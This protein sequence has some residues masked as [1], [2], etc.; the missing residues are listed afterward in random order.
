MGM[1]VYGK[2][3]KTQKGEYFRNNVWYWHPLWDYCQYVSPEIAT[4]VNY[5]HSNDG[6]GLDNVNARKLGFALSASIEDGTAEEYIENYYDM[7]KNSPQESCFCVYSF[8]TPESSF[9]QILDSLIK[10]VSVVKSELTLEESYD[11]NGSI[12]FPKTVEEIKPHDPK[13]DCNSCNGTGLVP[14]SKSHYHITLENIQS[15]SEFLI[16]CGG[17]EI[18]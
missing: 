2:K 16:D 18:C 6:D 4:K 13:P 14:N 10:S 7:V 17:F 1:D 9:S 3:P 8:N 12:P 15:F 11:K 5:P